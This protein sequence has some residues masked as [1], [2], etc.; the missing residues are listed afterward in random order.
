V[1]AASLQDRRPVEAFGGPGSFRRNQQTRPCV[2]GNWQEYAIAR[3]AGQCRAMGSCQVEAMS[4]RSLAEHGVGNLGV[5]VER[6]VLS[7]YDHTP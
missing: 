4:S 3:Y 6:A 1:P 2:A 5:K 7:G